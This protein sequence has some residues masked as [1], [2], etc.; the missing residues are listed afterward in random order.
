[1]SEPDHGRPD[2]H[3]VSVVMPVYNARRFLG[4]AIASVRAQDRPVGEIIVVDDGSTDGSGELAGT[5]GANIRVLRQD[6]TTGPAATRNRGIAAATG[7]IIGFLDADDL[8][9]RDATWRLLSR[10][11]AP[12]Q[13]DIVAGRIE[14]VGR[15]ATAAVEP[16]VEGYA[17]HFGSCLIRRRVFD[18]IGLL[19]P[20]L[21]YGEDADWFLRARERG[22]PIAVIDAVTMIYR[23][24]DGNATFRPEYTISSSLEVL[25]RSL[26]RRRAA[27]RGSSLPLWTSLDQ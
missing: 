2:N 17:M 5:L 3:S 25:K 21:R 26:D 1:M 11:A 24:H 9:P 23:R 27:G 16:P 15:S 6:R 10:L 18:E 19:D 4:E 12:S 8:W 14:V 7:A 13:P 22:V 20:A